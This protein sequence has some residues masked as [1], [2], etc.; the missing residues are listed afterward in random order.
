MEHR[1]GDTLQ[2]Y[3]YYYK[4]VYIFSPPTKPVC[5]TLPHSSQCCSK[6]MKLPELAKIT[7]E[8]WLQSINHPYFI[9][10]RSF[11][12]DD[13]HTVWIP[14]PKRLS[15][16]FWI[17][18]PRI[19]NGHFRAARIC[20]SPLKGPASAK[21]CCH[22]PS[23]GLFVFLKSL[24]RSKTSSNS[25]WCFK[26]TREKIKGGGSSDSISYYWV[27]P[28]CACRVGLPEEAP[29][30]SVG[31]FIVTTRCYIFFI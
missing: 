16:P 22:Q 26:K 31:C 8:L 12:W 18:S 30:N 23:E 1:P 20:H 9:P 6:D 17:H 24:T 27:K 11:L 21:A 28:I 19:L 13:E 4:H 10:L 25:K 29:C 3:H 14:E 2:D 15:T 7:K 5:E